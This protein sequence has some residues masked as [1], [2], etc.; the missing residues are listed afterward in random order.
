MMHV[1]Q[2]GAVLD[3]VRDLEVDAATAQ[4][5]AVPA[6][7]WTLNRAWP[8]GDGER[9]SLEYCRGAHRLAGQ[10]FADA[11]QRDKVYEATARRAHRDGGVAVA[12]DVLLQPHGADRRLPALRGLLDTPGV[13]LIVHRPERRAVVEMGGAVRVFAK[14]VHGGAWDAVLRSARIAERLPVPTPALLTAG[15]D[16][17]T[18]WSVL[19]GDPLHDALSAEGVAAAARSVRALHDAWPDPE[20]PAHTRDDELGVID[21]WITRLRPFDP[22]L[23]A[24]L[25]VARDTVAARFADVP[26]GPAAMIHRD[27]H[28]KQILVAGD[29]AGLLDFDMLAVGEPALDVANLLVHLELRAHQGLLPGR[30]AAALS[31]AFLA[32]YRPSAAVRAALDAYAAA[33]RVRLAAVYRFRPGWEELV[34]QLLAG[35]PEVGCATAL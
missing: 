22:E 9:L 6:G 32:E 31:A 17:V 29:R 8:R 1:I 35:F 12:E 19:P 34:P 16:G 2:S 11:A 25:V 26:E 7:A 24:Q 10:W 5:L 20:L 18:R 3:A 30:D 4:E 23:A 33:T 21:T 27:L 15:G 14:V 28:D 13:R